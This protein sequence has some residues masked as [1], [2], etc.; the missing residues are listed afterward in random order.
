MLS[1]KKYIILTI[2]IFLIVTQIGCGVI[3]INNKNSEE[4]DIKAYDKVYFTKWDSYLGY[5]LEEKTGYI[6]IAFVDY[7]DYNN[8]C[9]KIKSIELMPTNNNIEITNFRISKGN[10]H[11]EKSIRTAEIR[12]NLNREGK[13]KITMI[14]FNLID[15]TAI[16]WDIGSWEIEIINA[17]VENDMELGVRSF[18]ESVLETY[19]FELKNISNKNIYIKELVYNLDKQIDFKLNSNNLLK[20]GESSKVTYKVSNDNNLV[21]NSDFYYF[22][23]LLIYEIENELKYYPLDFT[24]YS[25]NFSSELIDNLQKSGSYIDIK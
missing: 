3:E 1:L 7:N 11:G 21:K 19:F 18:Y 9:S 10:E 2:I 8:F 4:N 12:F 6:Q 17:V 20:K 24:V 15:D 23:P 5:T 16:T 13:E 22:K 25:G 14:K